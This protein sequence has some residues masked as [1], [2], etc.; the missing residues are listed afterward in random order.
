VSRRVGTETASWK[1]LLKR[2]PSQRDHACITTPRR[3]P[4]SV[5]LEQSRWVHL[6]EFK[7]RFDEGGLLASA[8]GKAIHDEQAH[9]AA[10]GEGFDG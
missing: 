3:R 1:R 6:L 9:R 4:L 5:Y 10:G 2:W 7:V 8:V